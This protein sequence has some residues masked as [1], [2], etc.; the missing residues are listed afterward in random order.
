MS[1]QPYWEPT[2]ATNVE[3]DA[4]TRAALK[5]MRWCV[6]TIWGCEIGSADIGER[7]DRLL[8]QT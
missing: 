2:L 6:L 5:G 4:S 7:I 1:N 3:R 8:R